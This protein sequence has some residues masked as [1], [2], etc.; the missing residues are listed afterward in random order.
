MTGL[1]AI[2]DQIQQEA[3]SQAEELLSAARTEAESTLAAAREE[4][5][6]QSG[7]IL[8]QAQRQADAIRERAEKRNQ[9]LACKQQLIRGAVSK[10]CA[11]LENA[12]AEEYFSILLG[13]VARYGQ[14][15]KGVMTLNARDLQRLPGE[16]SEALAKAAPQGDIEISPAPG[17]MEG[18]F[19]LTY[20]PVQVDCTFAS[21]FQEAYEQL[22]DAAGAILFAPM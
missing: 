10:V 21:L 5:Q 4:A 15:G 7:E 22:R 19:V 3:A 20:G 16:F 8:S 17:A 11:S 13:L 2:L 6:R 1:E 18:G 14:P 12:P 9:L